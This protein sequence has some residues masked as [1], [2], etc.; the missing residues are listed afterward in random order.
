LGSG[1]I[2]VS[3]CSVK[4]EE[5]YGHFGGS[6]RRKSQGRGG[7]RRAACPC[8]S[9]SLSA[10]DLP[11]AF[12]RRILLFLFLVLHRRLFF[13]PRSLFRYSSILSLSH[14]LLSLPPPPT[15]I[16]SPSLPPSLPH[17]PAFLLSS[18]SPHLSL[19]FIVF[20]PWPRHSFPSK[21]IL[22][23][24]GLS[25]SPPPLPPRAS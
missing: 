5:G 17:F 15:L 25:P 18:S 14:C 19:S 20:F 22:A 10:V 7:R 8:C 13:F 1:S 2:G 12:L 11:S 6:E 24:R 16:L 3:W 4:F 9:S 21:P 23:W